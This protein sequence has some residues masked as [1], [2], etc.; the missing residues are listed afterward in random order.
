MQLEQFKMNMPKDVKDW[1]KARA[2]AADRSMSKEIIRIL[3][4]EMAA[5][6][7]IGVLSP[8]T[9]HE[10]IKQTEVQS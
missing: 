1:A 9:C 6:E 3:R 7:E 4:K 10:T 5:E 8:A 2:H